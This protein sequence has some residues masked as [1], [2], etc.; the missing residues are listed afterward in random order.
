MC[1]LVGI[2]GDIA[3]SWKDVFNEL[4]L[5]DVVRGPH[6]TGVG[7]VGRTS[8]AFELLKRPGNPFNLF[9]LPQY[10]KMVNSSKRII[11]GHNRYATIGEKTEANAHP[12]AF[13]NVI[14]M[15]NGTLD[16][17]SYKN[18][19]FYDEYGTDSETIF[20]NIEANG[21]KDTMAEMYGAW[22]LIWYDKRDDRLHFLRND[23]RPLHYAYSQ[24]K[25]TLVWS[26][27]KELLEYVLNRRNK[28]TLDDTI[29]SIEKDIHYSWKVPTNV[30]GKFDAPDRVEQLG[31]T[32]SKVTHSNSFMVGSNTGTTTQ[33]DIFSKGIIPFE[34]RLKTKKFRHPYRDQHNY[35]LTRGQ[36][37]IMVKEG[38]AFC[39]A[40]NQPWN[41]FVQIMGGYVGKTTPYACE[42]CFNNPEYYEF[43]QYAV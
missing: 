12:F 1:G 8:D 17:W 42:E 18:L 31:K 9:G 22:A 28:K 40:N 41:S 14:G 19:Q 32:W 26:S 15:H 5:F 37:D 30:N 6:S 38:C 29:F 11:L 13:Q 20:A 39:Q 2:A 27:E 34:K 7:T 33:A 36:Y 24:D 16:K 10:D 25:C 35:T 21:L 23:R 4:L 3:P 43:T